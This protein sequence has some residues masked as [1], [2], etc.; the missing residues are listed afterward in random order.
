MV[1]ND[2]PKRFTVNFSVKA[3]NVRNGEHLFVTG[4]IPELGAWRASDAFQLTLDAATSAWTGSLTVGPETIKF[5]YFTG[6]HLNSDSNAEPSLIMSKWETFLSPRYL[7]PIVEEKDGI[8]KP[9]L[10]DEFGYHAGKFMISDGWILTQT[11]SEILLRIHGSALRFYKTR[12]VH[13]HYR[14]KVAPFDLRQKQELGA[15]DDI[16]DVADEHTDPGMPSYSSTDIAALLH[17]DPRYHDQHED[18][19]LFENGIDYFI[20]RTQSVAVEY[21]GFRIEVYGEQEGKWDMIG[22][23]Y[24]MPSS[25]PGDFGKASLP[26]MKKNGMPVGKIDV[27]YLFIRPLKKPHPEQL[28]QVSYRKHWKKRSTLEVGHRG[29]GNS[30]SKFAA[31]RENTLHSLNAAAKKGA[32]YVEFDV[33]LTKDKVAVV[34]HDFHVLVSVAKRTPSLLNL[35]CDADKRQIVDLHEMAVKDLKYE[36][37]RLLHL[38]HVGHHDIDHKMT[39]VTGD[40][41]EADEFRPFPRLSE[42][43]QTVDPDVGFNI[44]VKYPMM[45]KDGLHECDNYFER[46]EVIDII[47][48]DV[49]NNAGNRR[50]VFSSFDPDI[51]TMISLKQSKYPV[52]FLC[53]GD[54]TRYVPFLDQR[55]STSLTAVNFAAGTGLLGVNFHSED[56]LRTRVPVDRANHFGLVSFVWGDDL[57]TKETLDYFKKTL[58]VDGI[59]YD[60]IGEIEERRNVFL[61]EREVK[62][63]LFKASPSPTPSRTVSFS[64]FETANT[65]SDDSESPR[66]ASPPTPVLHMPSV[67]SLNISTGSLSV[68]QPSN[69]A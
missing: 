7:M 5:R 38:D 39:K 8:C 40:I 3:P 55:S 66:N 23:A 1:G 28:T 35:T 63:G 18:G 57:S 49:L 12:H 6:Y 42:A 69:V 60:R 58:L 68:V 67:G 32:D 11:Q 44:E 45:Q 27:D 25:M 30:Y 54:T 24:A 22:L 16:E 34:F 36:Q 41:N 65:N 46:N 37:L 29:M 53:V 4:S 64:S 26:I 13:K 14:L 61:V 21:L 20:Y 2:R 51:C 62:K 52:L 10:H 15:D 56:L 43:L 31:T 17:E 59:I 9:N 19:D 50:I 47:L 48:S 33:Q